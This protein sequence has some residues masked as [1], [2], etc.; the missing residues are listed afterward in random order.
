[1]KVFHAADHVE[2]AAD[3]ETFTGRATRTS[4]QGVGTSPLVN[5]YRVRFD[6][7]A[8]TAWHSHTGPQILLVIE[9]TCRVQTEGESIEEVAEGGAIRIDPNERHWHGAS[10][11]AP[12]THLALNIDAR[13]DWFER[14]TDAQYD[15]SNEPENGRT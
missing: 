2:T 12:M 8:R 15:G 14:V 3:T 10:A 9:G 11:A 5:M 4:M 1:M 7:R 6:A 13:T